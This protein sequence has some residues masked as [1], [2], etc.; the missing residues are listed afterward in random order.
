MTKCLVSNTVFVKFRTKITP[1]AAL[2]WVIGHLWGPS[3][4]Y[5]EVIQS[6]HRVGY[7]IVFLLGSTQNDPILSL[8]HSFRQ[9]PDKNYT[10]YIYSLFTLYHYNFIQTVNRILNACKKENEI[11][12]ATRK[13]KT[14]LAGRLSGL[15]TYLHG[16]V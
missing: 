14:Y 8:K 4:G 5:I 9:I 6:D 11:K 3:M 7:I 10:L 1:F 2:R 16:V 13:R 12:K 15:F